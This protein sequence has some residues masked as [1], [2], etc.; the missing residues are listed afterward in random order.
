MASAR[1]LAALDR[2]QRPAIQAR[3]QRAAL[4]PAGR[5]L[6][7]LAAAQDQADAAAD[8]ERLV[9][10][11]AAARQRLRA[12]RVAARADPATRGTLVLPVERERA[13]GLVAVAV[14]AFGSQRAAAEALGVSRGLVAELCRAAAGDCAEG[15]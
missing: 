1:E 14:A 12:L 10:E 8:V 13:A 5:A 7:R 3:A 11:L 2:R 6:A 9:C 4:R 15:E